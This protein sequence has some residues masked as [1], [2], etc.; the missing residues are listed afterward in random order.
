M[1][2]TTIR[3]LYNPDMRTAIEITITEYNNGRHYRWYSGLSSDFY[4]LCFEIK[5]Y[6]FTLTS[7]TMILDRTGGFTITEGVSISD[8]IY[9]I[10][11]YK[12]SYGQENQ[13]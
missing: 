2:P 10:Y 12:Q 6:L 3:Q 4:R 7:T 1:Q 5:V 11:I 9:T 13:E 8:T